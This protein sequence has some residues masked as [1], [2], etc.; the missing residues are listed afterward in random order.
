MDTLIGKVP[1]D[2]TDVRMA[3]VCKVLAGPSGASINQGARRSLDV[4]VVMPRDFR[5]NQIVED[6]LAM[7][8]LESRR[9]PIAVPAYSR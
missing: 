8:T 3:Q 9:R 1:G 7:I 5:N 2:W 6:N 4:P